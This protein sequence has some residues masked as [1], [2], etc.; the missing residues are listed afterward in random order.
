MHSFRKQDIWG[1]N[2]KLFQQKVVIQ[3]LQNFS[4]QK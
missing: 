1:K 3:K 2:D 4:F